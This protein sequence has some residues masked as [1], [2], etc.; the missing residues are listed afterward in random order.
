MSC[1]HVITQIRGTL[2]RAYAIAIGEAKY[3]TDVML[4]AVLRGREDGL[5]SAIEIVERCLTEA[6][7]DARPPFWR[8]ASRED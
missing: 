5:R 8:R 3:E 4:R 7:A 1:L 2:A 6:G